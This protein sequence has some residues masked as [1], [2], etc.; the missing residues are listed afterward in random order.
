MTVAT[1]ISLLVAATSSAQ[2]VRFALVIGHNQPDTPEGS[3]LRYA[4]DDAVAVHALLQ[5]AGVR[6]V[7]L[8][9]LDAE[10]RRMHPELNAV[11]RPSRQRVLAEISTLFEAMKELLDAGREVELFLCFR[12]ESD[13]TVRGAQ[14]AV[15]RRLPIAL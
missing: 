8:V 3:T 10:T 13:G 14:G 2:P 12:S 7:L 5:D 9:S 6:S 4:D 1:I 11:G 15:A